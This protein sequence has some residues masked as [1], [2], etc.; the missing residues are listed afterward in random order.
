MKLLFIYT[1][2]LLMPFQH[3]LV[4][5]SEHI[6]SYSIEQII[7]RPDTWQ[8]TEGRSHSRVILTA[9]SANADWHNRQSIPTGFELS[10]IHI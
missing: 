4:L 8:G 5:F 3:A 9:K 2:I 10:L 7:N 1:V 6:M